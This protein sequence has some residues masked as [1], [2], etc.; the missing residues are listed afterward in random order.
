MF[1]VVSIDIAYSKQDDNKPPEEDCLE[2][3]QPN[4][5][6]ETNDYMLV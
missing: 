2:E 3:T 4:V 1:E 6:D 5:E